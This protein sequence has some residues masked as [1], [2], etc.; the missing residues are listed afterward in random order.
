MTTYVGHL[1]IP[2]PHW[3]LTVLFSCQ[4][5]QLYG[6]QKNSIE[7]IILKKSY[8][9]IFVTKTCIWSL[10]ECVYLRFVP[11]SIR[12]LIL[13]EKF[14]KVERAIQRIK[15]FNNLP[16]SAD[17][18]QE[19][20]MLKDRRM[21]DLSRKGNIVDLFKSTELRKRSFLLLLGWLVVLFSTFIWSVCH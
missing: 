12:W 8:L 6:W 7:K 20:K 14:D 10:S 16:Q 11:E 18:L 5:I 9:S 17:V 15:S 1:V 2:L 19:I 3:G 21:S 13:H 4:A